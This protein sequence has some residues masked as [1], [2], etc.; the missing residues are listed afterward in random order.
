VKLRAIR[1]PTTTQSGR[2]P[3]SQP[4]T[5]HMALILLTDRS[6]QH[7]LSHAFLD[8]SATHERSQEFEPCSSAHRPGLPQVLSRRIRKANACRAI[9]VC[10]P[11]FR[12][13]LLG[14]GDSRT[15]NMRVFACCRPKL[16]N[17]VTRGQ[18]Q[19]GRTV[20]TFKALAIELLRSLEPP[21]KPAQ[22]HSSGAQQRDAA[23][24]KGQPLRS[25]R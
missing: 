22:L 1:P 11:S 23:P 24:I 8:S 9:W 16:H 25:R 18:G 15:S 12:N 2:L 5:I 3:R 7:L 19:C 21:P 6:S 17:R 4:F 20:V 10:A 14:T 13:W